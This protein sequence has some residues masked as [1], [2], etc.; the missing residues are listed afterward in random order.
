M[1]LSKAKAAVSISFIFQSPMYEI[2]GEQGPGKVEKKEKDKS[3]KT[4]DKT[5][6]AEQKAKEAKENARQ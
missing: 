6:K 4:Q 2:T 5:K 3:R 1:S